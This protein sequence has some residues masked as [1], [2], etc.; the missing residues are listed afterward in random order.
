MLSSTASQMEQRKEKTIDTRKNRTRI[1]ILPASSGAHS[2]AWAGA[3]QRLEAAIGPL[4]G[5]PGR[6]HCDDPLAA[7]G[8][9]KRFHRSHRIA[10]RLSICYGW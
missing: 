8:T 2:N 1:S 9:R 3:R 6:T 10:R 5:E 7:V 4:V